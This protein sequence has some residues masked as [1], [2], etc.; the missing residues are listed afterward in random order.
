MAVYTLLFMIDPPYFEL[1][2]KPNVNTRIQF[3]ILDG[4]GCE[5]DVRARGGVEQGSRAELHL[6]WF[7]I[8]SLTTELEDLQLCNNRG[9]F[10]HLRLCEFIHFFIFGYKKK[11]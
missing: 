11:V 4:M 10:S 6:F 7:A 5:W 1:K 8:D 9:P 2:T 3:P